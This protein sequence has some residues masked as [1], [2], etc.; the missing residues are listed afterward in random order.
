MRCEQDDTLR[1]NT[2]RFFG[3][4][5]TQRVTAECVTMIIHTVTQRLQSLI[6]VLGSSGNR[7]TTIG[8]ARK[9]TIGNASHRN[10]P[11]AAQTSDLGEQGCVG[12]LGNQICYQRVVGDGGRNRA[13]HG[14]TE[15][16]GVWTQAGEPRTK[17]FQ[18]CQSAV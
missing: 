11:L 16:N 5:V 17:R 12:D 8:V 15:C 1:R 10:I 2:T 18:V 9:Q 14:K 6:D 3:N 4:D 13:G 7:G